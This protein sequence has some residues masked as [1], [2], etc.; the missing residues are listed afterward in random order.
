MTKEQ[1]VYLSSYVDSFRY[2]EH[3]GRRVVEPKAVRAARR[4]LAA[5][6]KKEGAANKR[7]VAKTNAGLRKLRELILFGDFP[8]A[9]K[10][11]KEYEKSLA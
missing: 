2:K 6:D 4:V 1:Q 7:A 9:L 8:K 3:L 11:I 5:W 10:A